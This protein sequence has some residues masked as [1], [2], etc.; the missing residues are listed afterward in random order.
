MLVSNFLYMAVSLK[1][2]KVINIEIY[3]KIF[4]TWIWVKMWAH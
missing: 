3:W 2:Q 4:L 1:L